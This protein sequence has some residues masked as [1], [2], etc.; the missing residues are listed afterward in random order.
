MVKYIN[1]EGFGFGEESVKNFTPQKTSIEAIDNCEFFVIDG[2]FINEVLS[3]VS[4][5][6]NSSSK[7]LDHK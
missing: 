4:Q 3:R 5:D 1:K 7:L 6:R 2:F